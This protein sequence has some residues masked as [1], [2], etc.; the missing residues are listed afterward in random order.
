MARVVAGA[1]ELLPAR[2]AAREDRHFSKWQ[3]L[4]SGPLPLDHHPS[5]DNVAPFALLE[6][7]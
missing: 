5:A 4:Q 3:R 2:A 1:L 6:A 7:V